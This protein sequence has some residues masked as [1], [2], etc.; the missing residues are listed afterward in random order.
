MK[1]MTSGF[2]V[3]HNSVFLDTLSECLLYSSGYHPQ[4]HQW[5]SGFHSGSLIDCLTL[6][7]SL[8]SSEALPALSAVPWLT[9]W[10]TWQRIS[11]LW[12][13]WMAW[14][15]SVLQTNLIRDWIEFVTPFAM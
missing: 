4:L 14:F 15:A 7:G 8:A 6:S 5:F 12:R 3:F 2:V 10:L 11:L 9:Q 1:H 13:F